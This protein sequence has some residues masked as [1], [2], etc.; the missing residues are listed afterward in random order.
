MFESVW[1][2]VKI[3][4]RPHLQGNKKTEVVVVGAGLAGLLIA[5]YLQESGKQVIVL[6][7]NRIGSG[8]TKNTTAKITSQHNLIYNDL[9]HKFGQD[10]AREYASYNERAILEY[11]RLTKELQIDCDFEKKDSYVYSVKESNAL[12]EE[13]EAA[14]CLGID[15]VYT[16]ETALPFPVF[17]AVKFPNQAQFHPIK[18]LKAIAGQLE[19]YEETMVEKRK[20]DHTLEVLVSTEQGDRNYEVEAE[21]IVLANHYPIERFQGLYAARMYQEREN[22]LVVKAPDALSYG[23]YVAAE[24][25]GYSFRKYQ[26]YVI[27]AGQNHRPG[28]KQKLNSMEHMEEAVKHYYPNCEICYHMVNQDT[29]TLDHVPYIGHFTKNTENVYIATGFNKW[30]MTHSM[31]S[32]LLLREMICMGEEKEDSIF[33]PS[34]FNRKACK[35]ELK[36]HIATVMSQLTLKRFEFHKES[37]DEIKPGEGAIITSNGKKLAVYKEND[38]TIHCFLARCPHLG[39]LLEWNSVEQSWDCPCHGSRFAKDGQLING[40]AK[41]NMME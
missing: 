41:E 22:V 12:K 15:A 18:F 7:A 31:V 39:C 40:P 24:N 23:M 26:Q 11:E 10:Q 1:N 6:E 27:V 17:G 28:E 9:I 3:E 36:E 21:I 13:V 4:K 32:A 5:Y 2:E 20:G 25:K 14:N 35:D 33:N 16:T 8:M 37:M 30:G 38:G 19:I 34:R 29:I